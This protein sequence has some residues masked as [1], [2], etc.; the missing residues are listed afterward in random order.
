MKYFED[1]ELNQVIKSDPYPI[2]KEEVVEFASQWDPQPFHTCE[3]EAAKWP[4]G[5]TASGLHTF[6]ISIRAFSV[7]KGIEDHP[8]AVAGFGWDEVRMPHPVRPGDT[9]VVHA[10]VGSKRESNSKP[11]LGIITTHFEV[12]NQHQQIVM[13]YRSSSLVLKRP[14]AEPAK[15]E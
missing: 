12:Y 3:E 15:D 11:D 10:Y 5:L 7:N 14:S 1:I 6:A 2:E 4:L 9:L 8:A 13:S